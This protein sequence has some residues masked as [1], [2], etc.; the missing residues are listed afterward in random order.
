[1]IS[2][3]LNARSRLESREYIWLAT[4]RPDGRPHLVPLW[5]V[6]HEGKVYV[7]I[8]PT[9]VKGRNLQQNT[10]VSLALEDAAHAIIGEGNAIALPPPWPVTVN[11]L[12]QQKY[13][14]DIST[15][16]QYTQLIE[17]TPT[18]WLVW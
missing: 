15:D 1:M 17:I 12:F 8:E 10:Q 4:V 5:F 14:W 2:P 7:C 18:K 9:S 6:Y 3:P 16:P 13:D 11:V